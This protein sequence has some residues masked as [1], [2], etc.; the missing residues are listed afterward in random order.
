MNVEIE[1]TG[2]P[3][4]GRL[5]GFGGQQPAYLHV[6]ASDS[7]YVSSIV[8]EKVAGSSKFDVVATWRRPAPGELFYPD[9]PNLDVKMFASTWGGYSQSLG[10]VDGPAGGYRGKGDKMGDGFFLVVVPR[11]GRPRPYSASVYVNMQSI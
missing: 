11:P 10:L 7:W 1:T 9:D 6:N 3:F 2:L 8:W 4:I 5:T